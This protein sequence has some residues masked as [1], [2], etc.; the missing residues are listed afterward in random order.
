MILLFI[1]LFNGPYSPAMDLP[2]KGAN[3]AEQMEREDT[4][5]V[6]CELVEEIVR[7]IT[8]NP[9]KK[10]EKTDGN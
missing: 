5:S 7:A 1:I 10:E 3:G 9:P 2:G 4:V 8:S 6:T